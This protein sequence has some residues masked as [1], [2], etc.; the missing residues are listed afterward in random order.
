MDIRKRSGLLWVALGTVALTG[1]PKEQ[2]ADNTGGGGMQANGGG[3]K[4]YTIA[5]I[6]KGQANQF[7]VAMHQGA[8]AA[9]K[10]ENCTVQW[11]APNPEG[12]MTAQVNLVQ[13]KITSK[14]DGIV[15]AATEANAL[16]KPVKDAASKGIPVV[17]VDSGI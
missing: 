11:V 5:F 9:E 8:Q 13:N 1:C 4:K 17:T 15:L 12:D 3:G 14:V 6:P 7:W 10:E 16:V 2:P